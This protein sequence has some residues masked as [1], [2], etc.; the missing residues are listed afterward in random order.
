[1]EFCSHS[2][3]MARSLPSEMQTYLYGLVEFLITLNEFTSVAWYSSFR[4]SYLNHN[5]S[6]FER[7]EPGAVYVTCRSSDIIFLFKSLNAKAING[8]ANLLSR[9]R[10]E[11]GWN[12]SIIE[13]ACEYALLESTYF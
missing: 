1:M 7:T 2:Q 9:M 12:A 10:F 6:G 5:L 8:N 3:S 13:F 11:A 4:S